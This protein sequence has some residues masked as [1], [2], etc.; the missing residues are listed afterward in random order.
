VNP[1]FEDFYQE[2]SKRIYGRLRKNTPNEQDA[3]DIFQ[4]VCLKVYS[5][6]EKDEKIH[7]FNNWI[8]RVT[9]NALCDWGRKRKTCTLLEDI[10]TEESTEYSDGVDKTKRLESAIDQLPERYNEVI[11][12]Q[13]NQGNSFDEMANELQ[14]SRK[15]VQ[16]R[17]YR[18]KKYLRNVV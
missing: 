6:L 12:L 9:S 16:I 2:H 8:N 17:I 1:T 4:D 11:Q 10:C 5:F 18:A 14:I 13:Y 15:N 3:E 7:R